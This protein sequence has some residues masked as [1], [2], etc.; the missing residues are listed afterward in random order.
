VDQYVPH[1]GDIPPGN[2]CGQG[3]FLEAATSFLMASMSCPGEGRAMGHL[4]EMLEDH[5]ELRQEIFETLR[6]RLE[7][8]SPAPRRDRSRKRRITN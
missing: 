6:D 8:P 5:P 7:A 4:G 3:R 1:A 2:L